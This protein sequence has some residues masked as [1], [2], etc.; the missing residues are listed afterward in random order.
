MK[1]VRLQAM[2]ALLPLMHVFLYLLYLVFGTCITALR[3]LNG[4]RSRRLRGYFHVIDHNCHCISFALAD[5]RTS[6]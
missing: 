4:R 3:L 6:A 2:L 5:L 1:S